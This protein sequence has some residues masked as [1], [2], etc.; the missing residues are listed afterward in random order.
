MLNTNIESIL[1]YSYIVS[2]VF[3]KIMSRRKQYRPVRLQD[4]EDNEVA[5]SVVKDNEET[6]ITSAVPSSN[7]VT[8]L[9]SDCENAGGTPAEGQPQQQPR[10]NGFI[11][12][13][14]C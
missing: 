2:D 13:G 12:N 9:T 6:A 7:N 8:P 1:S 4:E 10:K 11:A 5:A 3:N 14:K